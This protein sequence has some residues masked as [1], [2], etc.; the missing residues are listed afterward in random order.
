MSNNDI[1]YRV[2]AIKAQIK[3][4]YVELRELRKLPCPS[5]GNTIE[6][7]G[8]TYW[9]NPGNLLT[10][11][12]EQIFQI[13]CPECNG[14]GLQSKEKGGRTFDVRQMDWI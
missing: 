12:D 6:L 3:G 14:T 10:I 1:Q 7:K 2:M 13:T 11:K 8:L 4:L 5:C 9:A